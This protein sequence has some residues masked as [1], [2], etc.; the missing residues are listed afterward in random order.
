MLGRM[1]ASM[2]GQVKPDTPVKLLLSIMLLLLH[3]DL[4]FCNPGMN[5]VFGCY[6]TQRYTAKCP[7]MLHSGFGNAAIGSV[8]A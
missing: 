5:A 7:A 2:Y 8:P 6:K 3:I 4:D 1:W